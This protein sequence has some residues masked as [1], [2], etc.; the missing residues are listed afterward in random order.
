MI[1]VERI[2]E[3]IRNGEGLGVEFK[4]C[5]GAMPLGGFL[6]VLVGRKLPR[7]VLMLPRISCKLPRNGC[8]LPRR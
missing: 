2:A 7:I 5:F 1:G 6:R 8:K 4:R 3:L